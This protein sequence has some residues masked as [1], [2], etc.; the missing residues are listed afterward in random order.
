MGCRV[1][2]RK[3]FQ[4]KWWWHGNN[5]NGNS[6]SSSGN[7]NNDGPIRTRKLL[8]KD[9]Y[10]DVH[11]MVREI[12][13]YFWF[14]M[15]SL[16]LFNSIS[17]FESFS[18][19]S[20]QRE[21]INDMYHCVSDVWHGV[22]FLSIS[23][24]ETNMVCHDLWYYYHSFSKAKLLIGMHVSAGDSSRWQGPL[25][26][27]L[28]R[29][30]RLFQRRMMERSFWYSMIKFSSILMAMGCCWKIIEYFQIDT[31]LVDFFLSLAKRKFAPSVLI[32]F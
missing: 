24:H 19:E 27:H 1:Q 4:W 11:T 2:G 8:C 31:G 16:L 20:H 7:G 28:F 17:L 3:E 6:N 15:A 13:G 14:F 22:S 18:R 30:T 5:G 29:E 12:K 10:E 23:R 21:H 26:T 32:V 9:K 25:Q